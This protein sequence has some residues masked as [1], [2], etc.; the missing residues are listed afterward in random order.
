MSKVKSTDVTAQ[1]LEWV[2]SPS[3]PQ[4]ERQARDVLDQDFDSPRSIFQ[5][6]SLAMRRHEIANYA[7][8]DR[9]EHR[10]FGELFRE[11]RF[12]PLPTAN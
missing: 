11:E 10:L 2:S 8:L 3:N 1:L 4:L 5:I 6:A 7:E 12:H 9:T